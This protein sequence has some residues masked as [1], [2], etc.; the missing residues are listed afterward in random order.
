MTDT[1]APEHSGGGRRSGGRAGRAAMRAAS[2]IERV[3]YLTRTMPPF[4]I[5][6][7][8][9]L[10]RGVRRDGQGKIL[11]VDP[12]AVVHDPHEAH[13]PLF[14]RDGDPGRPGIEGVFEEFL[15]DARRA[16]DDFAG[17]TS[18]E[19]QIRRTLGLV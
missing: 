3:P 1:A 17:G 7:D 2:V 14:E 10:A 4:E 18:D 13:A 16:F 19:T 6:G 9:E 12:R 15:D 5:L 8:P 11:G